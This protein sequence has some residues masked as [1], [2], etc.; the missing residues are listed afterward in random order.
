MLLKISSTAPQATD[1][2]FLL[3]KNPANLHEVEVAFGKAYVLQGSL[4]YRDARLGGFDAAALLEVIEHLD[5]A[6]LTAME[7]VIF[8]FAHPRHVIITTPNREYNV[9]FRKHIN[10]LD[11]LCGTSTLRN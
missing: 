7:R 3:H 11:F 2:G 4:V 9:M 10:T 1:I 8:E 6:R 5:A